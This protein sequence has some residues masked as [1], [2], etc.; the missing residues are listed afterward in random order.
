MYNDKKI[1]V[2]IAAAGSGKRMGGGIPKQYLSIGGMPILIK[3]V[4]AFE[5]NAFI[6]AIL[7][8]TNVEYIN[9]FKDELTRFGIENVDVVAGGDQRQ[10]SVYTHSKQC[11]K[12][13][14]M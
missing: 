10:D 11:Q 13:R 1:T 2:I 12:I 8:V 6:D 14:I 5:T 4:K 9:F 3:T 7:V